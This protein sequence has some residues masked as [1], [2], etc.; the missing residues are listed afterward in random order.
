LSI[1]F[2]KKNSKNFVIFF[3]SIDIFKKYLY[4]FCKFTK[5]KDGNDAACTVFFCACSFFFALEIKNAEI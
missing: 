2:S 5:L 4:F 3:I 1:S